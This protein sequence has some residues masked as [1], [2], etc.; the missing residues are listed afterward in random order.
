MYVIRYWPVGG[1]PSYFRGTLGGCP[2]WTALES[3]HQF[4]TEANA[5]RQLAALARHGRGYA[6]VPLAGEAEKQG[7]VLHLAAR[8]NSS[9][10]T[11][12]GTRMNRSTR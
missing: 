11:K 2:V 12:V 9:R 6:V 4:R 7:R 3:A 1:I 5:T 8:K 10:G